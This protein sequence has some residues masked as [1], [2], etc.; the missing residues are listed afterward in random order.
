LNCNADRAHPVGCKGCCCLQLFQVDDLARV[1]GRR[2]RR[3]DEHPAPE[4]QRGC[5]CSPANV[6]PGVDEVCPKHDK[7]QPASPAP[8][9]EFFR[10]QSCGFSGNI[11]E[12]EIAKHRSRCATGV[13]EPVASP[14]NG[15][16]SV[17]GDGGQEFCERH[18]SPAESGIL[19]QAIEAARKAG[20]QADGFI[21]NNLAV[22]VTAA[23]QVLNDAW[24]KAI[25]DEGDKI[26]WQGFGA[27]TTFAKAV[28]SRLFPPL[29]RP[30]E[31]RVTMSEANSSHGTYNVLLDGD[32]MIA[33]DKQ[34]AEIYRL[35][36]IAQLNQ[37]AAVD[38]AR[39]VGSR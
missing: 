39:K 34:D 32:H 21:A 6:L 31:E 12:A 23:A 29:A 1:S 22:T 36:L 15:P 26:S 28:R 2:V 27:E 19:A 18:G 25:Q 33:L 17:C 10:C 20:V 5:K 14:A 4:S 7:S 9:W 13:T 30:A 8:R 38:A 3:P 35:G 24:E 11:T 37:V 16:C